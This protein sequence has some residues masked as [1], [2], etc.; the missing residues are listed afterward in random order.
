[1]LG[2]GNRSSA[3]Y[4]NVPVP[5][6]GHFVWNCGGQIALREVSVQELLKFLVIITAHCCTFIQL[7][8]TDTI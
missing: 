4:C 1:V 8:I 3:S 2:S 7:S 6:A 5:M